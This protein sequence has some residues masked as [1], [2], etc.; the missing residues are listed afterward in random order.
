ML[1]VHGRDSGS[2]RLHRRYLYLLFSERDVL[3]LDKYVFN[4]E[5]HPFRIKPNER[6]S[7]DPQD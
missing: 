5:A 6:L 7:A 2:A 1:S 3:S 4:T